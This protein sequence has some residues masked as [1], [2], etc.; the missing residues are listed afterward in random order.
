MIG[1]WTAQNNKSLSLALALSLSRR[2]ED[3][4]EN[5]LYIITA[6]NNVKKK[7]LLISLMLNRGLLVHEFRN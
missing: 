5:L 2:L 6:W 4:K 7:K 1:R 3:S